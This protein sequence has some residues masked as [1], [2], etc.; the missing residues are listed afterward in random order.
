MASET[1]LVHPKLF[2]GVMQTG[3][4]SASITMADKALSSWVHTVG[5]AWN[6]HTLMMAILANST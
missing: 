5:V 3:P 1:I 2:F 4:S 6:L